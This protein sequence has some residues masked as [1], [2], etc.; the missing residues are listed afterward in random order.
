[1]RPFTLQFKETPDKVELDYSLIEYDETL[2]LSINKKTQ[3]PAVEVLCTDTMTGTRASR[4][5]SDSDNS[6]INELLD[7][8]TMTKATGEGVIDNDDSM[9]NQLMD[10][11]TKTFTSTESSDTD[12]QKNS[13]GDLID[14]TTLTESRESTDQDK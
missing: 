13:I 10:T 12:Q 11:A 9:V 3:L 6:L 5:V 1:M 2:S 4:E 8:T 14:T 7:T